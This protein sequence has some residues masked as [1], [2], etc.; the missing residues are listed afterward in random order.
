MTVMYLPTKLLD[1]QYRKPGV[2][3][4]HVRSE[5]GD[6]IRVR[7]KVGQRLLRK[8]RPSSSSV[9][10]VRRDG[11]EGLGLEE[12]G[13]WEVRVERSGDDVVQWPWP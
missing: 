9:E 5:D 2:H 8:H 4:R 12:E 3:S 10:I 1:A 11:P 13:P 7:V 6:V